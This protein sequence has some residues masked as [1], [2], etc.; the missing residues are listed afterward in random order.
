MKNGY[1]WRA[2]SGNSSFWYSNWSTHGI[3]SSQVPFVDIHDIQLSVHDVITNDG[4]HTQR[5]YTS[6]PPD[7]EDTINNTR[8]LFNP[9][10]KDVFMWPHNKNDIYSNKSGYNWLLSSHA[11]VNHQTVSWNW[12][13]RLKAPEKIKFLI[14]LACHEAVPTLYLLNHRNMVASPLC[15]RCGDQDET[16]FH[17]IR[18]C[19]FS[20]EI[21]KK[22][23]F[24][25]QH[26]FSSTSAQVWLKEGT[27][28]SKSILFLSGL[29]WIWRHRNLMCIGNKTLS[30]HHSHYTIPFFSLSV[31]SSGSSSASLRIISRAFVIS[32]FFI[33]FRLLCC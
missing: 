18:D 6:L 25:S 21:W 2:G 27:N 30:L 24:T 20:M 28:S 5:L 29:W 31:D 1:T 26:F 8:I 19:Q 22:I 17:C 4:H 16:F 15:T 11:A 10:I 3:L 7:L 9:S 14:W 23:G 33:V 12:I 13:W 32:F